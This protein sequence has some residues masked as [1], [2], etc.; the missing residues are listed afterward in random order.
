MITKEKRK[1]NN[2]KLLLILE[3]EGLSLEEYV[4]ILVDKALFEAGLLETK[5]ANKILEE[6]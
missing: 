3:E 4:H 2:E 5:S 1:E 6:L